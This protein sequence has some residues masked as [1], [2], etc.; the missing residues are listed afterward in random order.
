ML[1]GHLLLRS[2]T[3]GRLLSLDVFRG[4]VITAM[5]LVTDP[6]TSAHT[7]HQLRHAEWNGPTATD[8]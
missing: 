4:I 1:G 7:W 2:P 3:G 6:G 5:I 8:N